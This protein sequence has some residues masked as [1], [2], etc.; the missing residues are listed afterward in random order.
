MPLISLQEQIQ[1]IRRVFA[2]VALL[3]VLMVP[4]MA[5]AWGGGT[6][7][8]SCTDLDAFVA[9]Q[10]AKLSNSI[11]F[12]PP[13]PFGFYDTCGV[14]TFSDG[15]DVAT[16]TN[17]I[18]MRD[19]LGIA[20]YPMSVVEKTQGTTR[21]WY[22]L[23]ADGIAFRTNDAPASMDAQEWVRNAYRHD[24]PQW[25]T[26]DALRQWYEDRDRCRISLT[27][28]LIN[29]NSWNAILALEAAIAATNTFVVP[30]GPVMPPDTNHLAF[31]GIQSEAA[32]L[33]VWVYTPASR[34]VALFTR[35]NLLGAINGWSY[36]GAIGATPA[37]SL[38]HAPNAPSNAFF[39]AGYNDVDSDGDG[40]PDA[41]E[42]LVLGTDPNYADTVGGSLGDYTRVLI[43]GLDPLADSTVGD[44]IPDWWKIA[45]GINPLDPDAASQDPD[46]DNITNL[47]EYLL[48]TDPQKTS[49]YNSGTPGAPR[50]TTPL[51]Y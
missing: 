38:W 37:F 18:P 41:L 26:E 30:S 33:K 43:Y 48:G 8:Q 32:D 42:S 47:G 27:M 1:Q 28:T 24:P 39:H 25:L 4:A 45:H 46:G 23:D 44:G 3:V 36:A 21:V 9:D 35:T 16:L 7:L 20:T 19:R 2:G 51:E 22:Y 12:Y 40:L 14:L 11:V 15:S 13:G 5:Q 49:A 10:Y 6:H 34:P 17:R 50:I 29:S 31:A